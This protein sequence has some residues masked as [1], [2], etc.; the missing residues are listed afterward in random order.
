MPESLARP[1]GTIR[2]GEK[3]VTLSFQK[4]IDYDS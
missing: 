3:G 2:V 4:G 1:I